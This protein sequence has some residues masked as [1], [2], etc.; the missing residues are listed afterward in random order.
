[1]R[2]VRV[3]FFVAWILCAGSIDGSL[4]DWR[5]CIIETASLVVLVGCVLLLTRGELIE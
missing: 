4:D 1:M 5:L 2:A 3:L